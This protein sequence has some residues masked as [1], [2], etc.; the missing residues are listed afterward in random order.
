MAN[1]Q[2]TNLKVIGELLG[3]RSP[4]TTT[5]YVHASRQGKRDAMKGMTYQVAV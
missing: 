1:K 3:H 4:N 2:K 5:K